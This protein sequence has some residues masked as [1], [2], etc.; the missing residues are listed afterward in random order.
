ME[1]YNPRPIPVWLDQMQT[2][3][4]YSDG[5]G[6]DAGVGVAIWSPRCKEGPLAAYLKVPA[7]VRKM[8]DRSENSTRRDIYEIEAIGPLVVL[9]TFPRL[10]QGCVWPHFIDNSAAQYSL[11]RGSSSVDSGDV[12]LG[13]TWQ[14]IQ[15]L[16]IHCP[17]PLES[18]AVAVTLP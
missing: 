9:C 8:W 13:E 1:S 2:A 4:S 17:H 3:I 15:A 18:S 5:E 6:A 11:I 10:V 16:R 7:E 14:Q 12:I